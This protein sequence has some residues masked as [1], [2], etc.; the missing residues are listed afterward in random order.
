MQ[1]GSLIT[2]QTDINSNLEKVWNCWTKPEHIIHWNFAAPEWNCPKAINSLKV[3]ENFTY[4]MA[5][6]DGSFSFD[7]SGEYTK[8]EALKTIEYI[9]EDARKVSIHFEEKDGK[10]KLLESFE[11]E[12]TNADEMQRAGWQAILDNF[13]TYTESI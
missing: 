7:F 3:G 8:I 11:A 9:L 13:K 2:I 12:G 5:A 10:V 1:K 6:K 4:T